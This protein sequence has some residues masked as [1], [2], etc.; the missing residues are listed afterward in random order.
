M[1]ETLSWC[2]K[3]ECDLDPEQ[4][5]PFSFI[6]RYSGQT[7]QNHIFTYWR[8]SYIVILAFQVNWNISGSKLE[9]ALHY[10]AAS[11]ID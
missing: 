7:K 6:D 4:K 9:V 1:T 10:P 8:I 11:Q 5:I 2:T 3:L